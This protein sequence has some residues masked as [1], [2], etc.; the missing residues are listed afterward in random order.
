V[1]GGGFRSSWGLQ[2]PRNLFITQSPHLCGR[3]IRKF[4][5]TQIR[6]PLVVNGVSCCPLEEEE[7]GIG[8][9]SDVVKVIG[10]DPATPGYYMKSVY[11]RKPRDRNDFPI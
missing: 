10:E 4:G 2:Y 3:T 6:S 5:P 8:I 9:A 1:E 11:T 7:E